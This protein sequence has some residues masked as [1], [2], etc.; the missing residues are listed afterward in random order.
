MHLLSSSYFKLRF[1]SIVL[2]YFL[3]LFYSYRVIVCHRSVPNI[4]HCPVFMST[5]YFYG[6]FAYLGVLEH[7]HFHLLGSPVL[8][9]LSWECH[10]VSVHLLQGYII[11]V[12]ICV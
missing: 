10:I 8:R 3:S 9:F 2:S 7:L 12:L 6:S 4:T 11:V 5:M 1:R